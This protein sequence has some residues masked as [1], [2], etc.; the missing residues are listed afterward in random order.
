MQ[1]YGQEPIKA[2]YHLVKFGGHRYCDSEG[3]NVLVCDV[4]SYDHLIKGLFDFIGKS[5]SRKLA[6]LLS[7]VAKD[8]VV[9]KI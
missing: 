2:N 1:T 9:I 4:I 3:E 7:L 8:G 6:I 5:P